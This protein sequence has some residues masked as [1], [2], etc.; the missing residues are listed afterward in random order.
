ML[1]KYSF[2]DIGLK[3]INTIP[4]I[5]LGFFYL[6]YWAF[7][8]AGISEFKTCR[9]IGCP[10]L[11]ANGYFTLIVLTTSFY[12]VARKIFTNKNYPKLFFPPF[13]ILLLFLIFFILEHIEKTFLL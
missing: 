12:L 5:V 4:L 2:R 7:T 11:V 3:I 13:L 8:A 1:N 9:E 10:L 6:L